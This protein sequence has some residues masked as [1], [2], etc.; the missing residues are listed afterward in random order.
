MLVCLYSHVFLH[1]Q[2]CSVFTTCMY[3]S[4]SYSSSKTHVECYFFFGGPS[5]CP[6]LVVLC[7]SSKWAVI[8]TCLPLAIGELVQSHP[9]CWSWELCEDSGH[10]LVTFLLP[11]LNSSHGTFQMLS[12]EMNCPTNKQKICNISV[13]KIIASSS[14]IIGPVS[15]SSWCSF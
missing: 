15:S 11:A 3:I 2:C 12:V 9:H 1:M 13:G 7:L 5:H 14:Y 8:N 10:V 6:Q 4:K